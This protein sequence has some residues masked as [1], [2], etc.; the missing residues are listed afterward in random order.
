MF[1]VDLRLILELILGGGK[2]QINVF[3]SKDV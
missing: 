3:R 2:K 1:L